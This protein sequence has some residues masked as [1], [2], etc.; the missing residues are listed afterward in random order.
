MSE[1]A[2]IGH[3][4]APEPTPFDAHQANVEDLIAEAKNWLDG[5][6]IATQGQADAVG[7]LLDSIRKASKDV[8]EQ[9]KVEKKPHDDAGK[10]VQALWTPLLSKC[11]LAAAT[12]KKALTPWLL[13]LQAEQEAAAKVAREAALQAQEEALKLQRAAQASNDLEAAERAKTAT[14]EAEKAGRVANKAEKAAPN[15]TGGARSVGLRTTYRAEI[16]DYTKFAKWAWAMRRADMEL[17]LDAIAKSEATGP[18][19]IDG[20]IIHAD[21][22]AV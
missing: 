18:K 13:K 5:E 10:A 3:N 20:L 15:A 6:P 19:N 4:G 14:K 17:A 1:P 2:P 7:V 22:G 11:D 9:R 16:T 8:D 21:Q 12:A